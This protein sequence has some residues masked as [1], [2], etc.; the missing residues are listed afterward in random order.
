MATILVVED[1]ELNITLFK[2]V[3]G[4]HKYNVLISE[5][6]E[7]GYQMAVQ[8]RPDLVLLDI[9]LPD[10]DGYE[11]AKRLRANSDTAQIPII[12][13]TSYAMP[14]DKERCKEAGC[15]DF[16]SKPINFRDLV[17]TIEKY[18]K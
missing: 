1:N 7:K 18:L 8:N 4:F 17:D 14:E 15:S 5:S 10:I 11:V 2:D 9:Q 16:I 13:V 6:G 12:A 3:L